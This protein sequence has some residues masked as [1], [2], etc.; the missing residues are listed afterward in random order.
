MAHQHQSHRILM[1]KDFFST[2]KLILNW[3]LVLLRI[4]V[5][6]TAIGITAFILPGIHIPTPGIIDFLFLG[7]VFGLLNAF[8]KP[9]IQVL[10]ISLLFVT[11]G[12]VVVIINTVMLF[13]LNF[14]ASNIMEIDSLLAGVVGGIII[15][16]LSLLMDNIFGLT[17]PIIDDEAFEI[18]AKEW[19]SQGVGFVPR[20]TVVEMDEVVVAPPLPAPDLPVVE[21]VEAEV[22]ETAVIAPDESITSEETVSEETTGEE[23][24]S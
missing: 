6:G 16:L 2:R 20:E 17:P 11:Y 13:I 18:L 14:L 9:I 24:A 23:N 10:T 22:R 3:K 21:T 12:L 8:I 5:N 15:S 4:L 19:P 1:R 7:L